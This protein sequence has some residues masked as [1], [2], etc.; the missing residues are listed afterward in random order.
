MKTA[1][2]VRVSTL[3][4]AEEGYSI[5]EQIDKLTNY[6]KARDWVITDIYTDPGFSGSSTDR[7]GLKKLI[8]DAKQ[9]KYDYVLVYK[10]DRLSRS[11]KDTLYLIEDVFLKN[12]IGFLSLQESFDTTTAFGKAVVGI[13]AVFAQLEREQIKE[14][15]S[16]G[17]LGRAKSG[18]AMSWSAVPYGYVYDDGKYK[19]DALHASVV[20]RIFDDYLNGVSITKLRDHLNE[21]GHIGKDK[22]WSYRTI[23]IVLDNPIYAGYN[24]FKNSLYQGDHKPIIS[25]ETYAKTQSELKKR[26][27]QVY[28]NNNNPRPFQSKYMLSGIV[29]CGICDS[30]LELIMNRPRKDGTRKKYYRCVSRSSKNHSAITIRKND[31]CVLPNIDK[32]DIEKIVLDQLELLRTDPSRLNEL[33]NNQEDLKDEIKATENK[34]SQLDKSLEKL[35][36]LYLENSIS[37]NI[38]DKRKNKIESERISLLEKLTALS[39]D[40]DQSDK[41]KLTDGLKKTKRRVHDLDYADQKKLVN[42]LIKKVYVLPD[43]VKIVWNF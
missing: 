11:Q 28:A 10:L 20:R 38:L 22:P 12:N 1:I 15:M 30:P 32:E 14:R 5:D 4:Q 34:L 9:K 23:R 2:Y 35:V 24:R 40:L 7:P 41:G 18:K 42:K 33:E 16:M 13:L 17:K 29:R 8:V 27:Q 31:N 37:L 36:D 26:Q 25:W 39:E 3:E 19:I 6:C 21:E 43:T